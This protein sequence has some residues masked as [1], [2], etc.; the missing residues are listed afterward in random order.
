[1]Q[2][3]LRY[4]VYAEENFYEKT[5]STAGGGQYSSLLTDLAFTP[6]DGV[7]L[8]IQANANGWSAEARHSMLP[9][10][11]CAIFVGSISAPS[12]AAVN[13]VPACL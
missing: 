6:T 1:M 5:G 9:S 8:L 13:G 3:D 4:L 7:T 11:L 12:P 10:E 2:A